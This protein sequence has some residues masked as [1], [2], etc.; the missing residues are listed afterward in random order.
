MHPVDQI[1]IC[2][3]HVLEANIAEDT[4]IIDEYVDAAKGVNGGFND[5]FAILDRVVVGNC[6]AAGGFDL[7]YNSI[8]SL[9]ALC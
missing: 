7:V 9:F 4:R 3:L 5:G 2:L 1:P 8:C 6:F